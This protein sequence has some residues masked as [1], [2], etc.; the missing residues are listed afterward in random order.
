MEGGV[1]YGVDGGVGGG[2]GGGRMLCS[3]P[4]RAALFSH[5]KREIIDGILCSMLRFRFL[6]WVRFASSLERCK[7]KD[8]V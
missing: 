8:Y 7:F 4:S 2:V 1:L 3:S 6:S 5:F